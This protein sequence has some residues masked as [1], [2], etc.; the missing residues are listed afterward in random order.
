M[1]P[2]DGYVWMSYVKKKTLEVSLMCKDLMRVKRITNESPNCTSLYRM[3][4][5]ITEMPITK[6]AGLNRSLITVVTACTQR[7]EIT[8]ES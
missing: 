6:M 3:Y 8:G 1:K 2:E 5:R 4:W 7:G